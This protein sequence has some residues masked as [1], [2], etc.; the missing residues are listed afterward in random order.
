MNQHLDELIRSEVEHALAHEDDPLPDGVQ[1]THPNR[2]T[3]LSIRLTGDEFHQLSMRA[4]R[5]GMP[6]STAARHLIVTALRQPSL[7]TVFTAALRETLNP[8][9]LVAA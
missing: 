1:V 4:L 9:L 3:V 7:K 6:V 5:D 2:G 8:D